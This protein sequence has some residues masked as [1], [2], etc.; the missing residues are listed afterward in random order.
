MSGGRWDRMMA[1]PVPLSAEGDEQ[2][3]A[4]LFSMHQGDAP[5]S[6]RLADGAHLIAWRHDACWLLALR[7][8]AEREPKQS[9]ARSNT[10]EMRL[11]AALQRRWRRAGALDRAHVALGRDGAVY[12]LCRLSLDAAQ[13]LAQA[14]AQRDAW[15]ALLTPM[16]KLLDEG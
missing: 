14:G 4:L 13:E 7:G 15:S 1:A 6:L 2:A 3:L 8:D 5:L 16:R 11:R 12:A 9:L 10:S